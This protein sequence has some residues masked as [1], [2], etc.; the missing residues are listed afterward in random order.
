MNSGSFQSEWTEFLVPVY[1]PEPEYPL[2]H[3][4]SKSGQFRGISVIPV[5]F[6]K[7]RPK[8]K[9]RL[10]CVLGFLHSSQFT[11]IEEE[12]EEEEER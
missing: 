2:F 4:W 7:Y 5:C 8:L 6:G 1:N 3:L 9:I 11:E 12:E 10:I